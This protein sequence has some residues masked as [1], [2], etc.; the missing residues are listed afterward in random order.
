MFYKPQKVFPGN[1]K[2]FGGP[3]MARGP[4]VARPDLEREFFVDW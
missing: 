4:N 2:V 1:I 3:F